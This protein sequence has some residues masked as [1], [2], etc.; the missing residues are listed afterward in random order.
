MIGNPA[1]MH[2]ASGRE[3]VGPRGMERTHPPPTAIARSTIPAAASTTL[4]DA[5][6]P[7]VVAAA[8]FRGRVPQ[9]GPETRLS[10]CRIDA[11]QSASR[12]PAVRV[13]SPGASST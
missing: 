12:C 4:A 3:Q 5:V 13:D 7:P 8:A 2:S 10:T 9:Q 6:F 11:V 1:D